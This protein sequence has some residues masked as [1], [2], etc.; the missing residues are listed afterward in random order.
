MFPTLL[1]F[2]PITISAFGV[3]VALSLV[4]GAFIVWQIARDRGLADEKILDNV[5]IVA[6]AAFMSARLFFGITHWS[7]FSENVLR[8]FLIW[9]FPGLSMWGAL[10]GGMTVFYLYGLKQKLATSVMFDAY[11]TALVWMHLFLSAGVFLDGSLVGKET[12]WPIGMYAVGE[13][14]KRQ[15]VALYAMILTALFLISLSF[16]KKYL[17]KQAVPKGTLGWVVLAGIGAI[18]LILA[19]FRAN[20]LYWESIPVEGVMATI[21]LV[22]P[23]GP[24][25]VLVD[26]KH[27][28]LALKESMQKRFK[29]I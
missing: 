4:V 18:Q 5:V 2:G 26:G 12:K 21:F 13:V 20:L 1:S 17:Q 7:L 29:K 15:P 22:S 8:L 28:L 3:S 11:S 6:V 27:K 9:K 23:V 25:F 24:L 16:L 14:G 10:I 19:Y